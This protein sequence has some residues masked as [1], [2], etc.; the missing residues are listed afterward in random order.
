MNSKS[1]LMQRKPS[2]TITIY[3]AVFKG[4]SRT[5]KKTVFWLE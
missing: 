2:H 1:A 3:S 4:V 5:E